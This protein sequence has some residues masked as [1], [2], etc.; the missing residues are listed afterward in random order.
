MKQKIQSFIP[1][2]IGLA[3]SAIDVEI[4]KSLLRMTF[5]KM[6]CSR[7]LVKNVDQI[8]NTLWFTL[9][10]IP[11]K[12]QLLFLHLTAA[13]APKSTFLA[14]AFEFCFNIFASLLFV[15]K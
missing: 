9:R 5:L 1:E 3:D 7:L 4:L 14:K 11:I 10:P 8:E 12:S 6:H 15:I 13:Q 2:D